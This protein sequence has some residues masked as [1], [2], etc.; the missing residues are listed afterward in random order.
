MG[1]DCAQVRIATLSKR[2]CICVLCNNS[3]NLYSICSAVC[4]LSGVFHN[5]II[6]IIICIVT[7]LHYYCVR[8]TLLVMYSCRYECFKLY[9]QHC[10]VY[11][12]QESML[13]YQY[14]HGHYCNIIISDLHALPLIV[15]NNNECRLKI[16]IHINIRLT[17]WHAEAAFNYSYL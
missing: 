17:T 6:I 3:I 13:Q 2:Y 14:F 1:Q 8:C 4:T 10:I 11:L 12:L 16:S 15:I 7:C 5:I 9:A